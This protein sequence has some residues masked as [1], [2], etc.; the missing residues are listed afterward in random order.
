[1]LNKCKIKL[2]R[3]SY[4]SNRFRRRQGD[5]R[6]EIE[7]QLVTVKSLPANTEWLSEEPKSTELLPKI[8]QITK[9]NQTP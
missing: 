1:M 4:Q 7:T 5:Q 6:A 9:V 2:Q 8:L 3:I